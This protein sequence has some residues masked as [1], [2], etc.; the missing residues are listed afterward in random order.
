MIH[1]FCYDTFGRERQE[2]D[3]EFYENVLQVCQ[4]GAGKCQSIASLA[5]K[6][7]NDWSEAW[8]GHVHRCNNTS[9]DCR[10]NMKFII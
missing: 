7:L 1:D 4:L 9:C 10:K 3:D 5:H 8:Y 6:A 2:C